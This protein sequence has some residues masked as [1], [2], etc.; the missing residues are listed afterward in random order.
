MRTDTGIF[1]L[2]V[3]NQVN[4]PSLQK[5]RTRFGW[6]VLRRPSPRTACPACDAV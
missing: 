4:L 5:S 3:P 6:L 2:T 1:S